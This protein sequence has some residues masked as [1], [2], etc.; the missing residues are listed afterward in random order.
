MQKNREEMRFHAKPYSRTVENP[1]KEKGIEEAMAETNRT[2]GLSIEELRE[3]A[4]M[5]ARAR[6]G[7][8]KA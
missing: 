7:E 1:F 3:R 4:E 6:R 5:L 8:R 2:K